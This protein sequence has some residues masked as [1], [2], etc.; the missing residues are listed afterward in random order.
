MKKIISLILITVI[1]TLALASC[2][3]ANLGFGTYTFKHARV[4]VG[5]DTGQC[6]NIS[7]WHDNEL[8]IELHMTN[9]DSMYCS[10]GTY[11]LFS[12]ASACPF[13]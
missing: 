11:L 6:F 7:S 3:N 2:G 12:D 1:L 8:G 13:C 5:G 9:G 4:A 10:E